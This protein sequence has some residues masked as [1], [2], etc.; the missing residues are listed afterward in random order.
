M[1]AAHLQLH[2]YVSGQPIEGIETS[3]ESK[4][5]THGGTDIDVRTQVGER[6]AGFLFITGFSSSREI[7]KAIKM[8]IFSSEITMVLLHTS[9][10][11]RIKKSVATLTKSL[12]PAS[13]DSSEL[14][15]VEL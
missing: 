11:L 4:V 7:L 6:C 8:R 9:K 10:T 15:S 2:G 13:Q 14:R 3:L 5:N 12:L 1:N